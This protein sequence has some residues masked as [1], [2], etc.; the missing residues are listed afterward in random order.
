MYHIRHDFLRA[1]WI[2]VETESVKEYANQLHIKHFVNYENEWVK[3][4]GV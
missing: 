1:E 4:D 2:F 3:Y